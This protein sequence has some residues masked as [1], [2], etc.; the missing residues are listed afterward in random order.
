[1]EAQ[2]RGSLSAAVQNQKLMPDQHRFCNDRPQ[3]AWS[4]KPKRSNDNVDEKNED[5]APR[6]SYQ[7]FTKG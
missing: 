3:A 1:M 7:S 2:V 4:Q 6:E 5:V